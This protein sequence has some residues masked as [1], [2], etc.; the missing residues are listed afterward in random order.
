[1]KEIERHDR[2]RLNTVVTE[3]L[4]HAVARDYGLAIVELTRE[5][6]CNF[7]LEAVHT[8]VQDMKHDKIG[9]LK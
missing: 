7:M 8:R 1:M 9:F 4:Q 5:H 2:I 6:Y 3:D